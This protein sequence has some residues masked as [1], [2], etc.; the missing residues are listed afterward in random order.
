MRASR[1]W[2]WPWL[3]SFT[4]PRNAGRGKHLV[5]ILLENRLDGATPF[6]V[7]FL[8]QFLGRRDAAGDRFFQRPQIARFV[9][10]IAVQLFA[11]RQAL[12]A[13]TQRLLRQRQHIAVADFRL[14]AEL[15]HVVAQFLSLRRA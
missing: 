6:A 11:A 5:R 12:R 4:T 10:A 13:E 3:A 8:Q 9:A 7:E 15:G 2:I 14:E 1:A